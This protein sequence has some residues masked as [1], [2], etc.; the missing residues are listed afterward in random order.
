MTLRAKYQSAD[1]YDEPDVF[2]PERFLE[3]K[4]GT[5]KGAD[6]SELRDNFAFGSGRVSILFDITLATESLIHHIYSGFV[7][8][9]R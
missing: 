3:S 9:K 2:R 5:K 6:V 1:L 8:A 4:Y 7:L